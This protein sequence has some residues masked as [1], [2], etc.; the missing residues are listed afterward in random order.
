MNRAQTDKAINLL[1]KFSTLAE[2]EKV[3]ISARLTIAVASDKIRSNNLKPFVD[4]E[5]NLT[6]VRVKD[7]YAVY[8]ADHKYRLHLITDNSWEIAKLNHTAEQHSCHS[9]LRTTIDNFPN[10]PVRACIYPA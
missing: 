9:F 3:D 5:D 6:F 8:G 10:A 7:G 2:G 4:F 1:G